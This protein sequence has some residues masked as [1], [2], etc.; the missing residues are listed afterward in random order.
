[1]AELS[2]ENKSGVCGYKTMSLSYCIQ[3]ICKNDLYFL[4]FYVAGTYKGGGV[5]C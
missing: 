5:Q 1:M 4:P 3:G 2:E